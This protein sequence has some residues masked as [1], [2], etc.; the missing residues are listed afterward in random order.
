MR[1]VFMGSDDIACPALEQL[2]ACE[3]VEIAAVVTQ[4]DRPSGRRR[5]L[6]PCAAKAL[7]LKLELPVLDPEKIGQADAVAQL[8]ELAPEVLVVVAYGQYIPERVR[9]I[10]PLGAINLHPSLLPRFRGASPIQ[11]TLAQGRCAGRGYHFICQQGDGC[12]GYIIAGGG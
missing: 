10:P 7:A 11:Q 5:H 12:R 1:I 6:A 8:Q 3:N 9:T 4:P 2:A